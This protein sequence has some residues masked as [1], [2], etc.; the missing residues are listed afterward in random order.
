VNL[1]V[2]ISDELLGKNAQTV[3]RDKTTGRRRDLDA[4]RAAQAETDAAIAATTAKYDA[5]NKGQVSTL[6][7]LFMFLW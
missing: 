1:P 7:M 4:E 3:V 2:Q 5:W 6:F